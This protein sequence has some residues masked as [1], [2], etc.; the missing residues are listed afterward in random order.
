M[1]VDYVLT[2]YPPSH[3][4]MAVT[5][6]APSSDPESSMD[7]PTIDQMK[8]MSIANPKEYAKDNK[9]VRRKLLNRI[10]NVRFIRGPK[11]CQG[12]LEYIRI[13]IWWR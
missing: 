7:P 12:N 13:S 6:L 10:C 4:Q 3:P 8:Y 1:E 5:I 9:T 2:T 11:I